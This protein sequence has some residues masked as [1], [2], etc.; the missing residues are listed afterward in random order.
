MLGKE[1]ESAFFDRGNEPQDRSVKLT[2][3][4]FEPRDRVSN[5]GFIKKWK[6]GAAHVLLQ[7]VVAWVL[8]LLF[9]YTGISKLIDW[10]GTVHHMYNQVFPYWI[11]GILIYL[12]PFSELLIGLALLIPRF[13]SMGFLL[14]FLAMLAFTI[15][16]GTVWIGLYGWVP[17]SCGGVISQMT[18]GEHLVF[19]LVFLGIAGVGMKL[20]D[21]KREK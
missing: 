13:R 15:Y 7:E 4:I 1:K 19:N 16:V 9:F 3:V 5:H 14:S 10:E 18:W 11:S 6:G 12:L 21:E 20:K 2:K 8:A 17:C